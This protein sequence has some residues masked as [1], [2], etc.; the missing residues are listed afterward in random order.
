MLKFRSPALAEHMRGQ[1]FRNGCGTD[2]VSRPQRVRG[3][4]RHRSNLDTAV[5]VP[6][7]R[8]GDTETG[9]TECRPEESQSPRHDTSGTAIYIYIYADICRSSGAVLGVNVIMAA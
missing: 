4:P 2:T 5:G 6:R 3:N 8:G 1:P 9:G 7:G